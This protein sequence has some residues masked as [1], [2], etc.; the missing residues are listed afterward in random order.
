MITIKF[1]YN[2]FQVMHKILLKELTPCGLMQV[3][4]KTNGNSMPHYQQLKLTVL[5]S[6]VEIIPYHEIC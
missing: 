6:T 3:I 1:F 5:D 2:C 4:E